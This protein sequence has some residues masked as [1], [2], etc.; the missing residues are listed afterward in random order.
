M[1]TS[2]ADS[3]VSVQPLR[4]LLVED[5]FLIRWSLAEVL[6]Q[7]G[8]LVVQASDA[9]DALHALS[10]DPPPDI[11]LLDLRL[12]DVADFSLLEAIRRDAPGATIVLMTAYGTPEIAADARRLG[13]RL[14][15]NKPFNMQSVERILL[16]AVGR[17]DGAPAAGAG[18]IANAS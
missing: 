9:A 1:L 13:A 8:H 4:V 14:V 15:L 7:A 2:A 11:V 12:P 10:G 16:D 6:G 17:P 5:E 3:T 18:L